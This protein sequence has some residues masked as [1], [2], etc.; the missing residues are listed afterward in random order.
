[1][2]GKMC[3]F[4]TKAQSISSTQPTRKRYERMYCVSSVKQCSKIMIWGAFSGKWGRGPLW[5]MPP[6][7]TMDSKVYQEILNIT[8]ELLST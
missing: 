5:L 1:M 3:Y 7:T 4:Q 6:G 8:S 2:I